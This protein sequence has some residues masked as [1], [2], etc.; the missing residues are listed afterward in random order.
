MY[1][2]LEVSIG[3]KPLRHD[4][5]GNVMYDEAV[6]AWEVTANAYRATIKLDANDG[7]GNWAVPAGERVVNLMTHAIAIATDF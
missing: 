4:K 5:A 1:A 2:N 3:R 6:R 7:T